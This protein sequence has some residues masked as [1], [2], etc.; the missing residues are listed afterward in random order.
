M[1]MLNDNFPII[2]VC[3]LMKQRYAFLFE[4]ILFQ[5]QRMCQYYVKRKILILL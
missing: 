5:V 3:L 4:I 1:I 2:Y